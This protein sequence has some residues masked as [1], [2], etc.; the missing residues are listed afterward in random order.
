M[1]L[2]E[3]RPSV[4]AF[5]HHIKAHPEEDAPRLILADWLEEHGDD[6][7]VARALLIRA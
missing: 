4:L 1:S 6:H 7:D 2:N 5:L 3:P